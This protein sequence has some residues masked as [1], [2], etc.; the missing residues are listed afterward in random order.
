MIN[1]LKQQYNTM[2]WL[3]STSSLESKFRNTDVALIV[4]ACDVMSDFEPSTV[5]P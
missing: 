5:L 1:I 2:K 3:H 4:S